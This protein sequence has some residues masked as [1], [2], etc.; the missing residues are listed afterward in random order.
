MEYNLKQIQSLQLQILRRVIDVCDENNLPYFAAYGTV[1]GAIRHHGMIPWDGD[2]DLFIPENELDRFVSTMEAR[3]GDDFWVDYRSNGQKQRDFPRIGLT[4]FD[5]TIIHVD[6]FRLA[7]APSD[8][9]AQKKLRKKTGRIHQLNDVKLYGF[10]HYLI[11]KRKV[12]PAFLTTVF[13][14]FLPLRQ[15]VKWIDRCCKKYPF[16]T[17]EYVGNAT[18][19]YAYTIF[20]KRFLGEGRLVKF[21][22]MQIRVP[23]HYDEYLTKMY[24]D[25]KKFPPEEVRNR[26]LNAVYIVT[27]NPSTGLKSVTRKK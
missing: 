21:E 19:P 5:T 4:G 1:L 27:E 16:E 26:T 7:G 6:V 11:N 2:I 9:E 17:S 20:P 22:D 25:Y 14:C 18:S 12:V 3:I 15:T 24:G 10:R 23:E 8:P 13:T